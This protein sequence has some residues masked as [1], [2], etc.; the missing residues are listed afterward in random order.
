MKP[1]FLLLFLAA[2]TFQSLT[3]NA[4]VVFNGDLEQINRKYQ[5]PEAWGVMHAYDKYNFKLD[6][7][8]VKHGKYAMS[9]TSK[10]SDVDFAAIACTISKTF[11][12]EKVQLTGYLKTENV[13]GYAGFWVRIDGTKAF[14]NM[15]DQGIKGTNDWKEYTIT[16]PYDGDNAINIVAGALMVGTGKIWFDDMKLYLDGKPIENAKAIPLKVSK[17]RF[18]TAFSEKSG[19][20]TIALSNN[21]IKNLALLGQAWGFVKYHLPTVAEGD[22][23]MDAELFRVMPAVLKAQNS[24]QASVVIE[25]WIDRLGLVPA[26]TACAKADAKPAIK[27]NYG[28]LFDKNVV[29]A[30][31]VQKLTNILANRVNGKSY[32]IDMAPG[33]NNPVFK[34]ELPYNQM[35]YPDAGYRLL[36]LFRYWNMVNYFSP[37]RLI[38]GQQWNKVLVN[39]IP[40]FVNDK[41][42]L[43]YELTTLSLIAAVNDTHANIWNSLKP[44]R[45]YKGELSP[46]FEA[47]FIENQLTVTGF[48]NDTLNVK[49]NF[50]V[51]DVITSINGVKVADLIKKYLPYT[52]ASNY[53]TQLRDLPRG[54]LL[55]GNSP[56]VT[57]QVLRDGHTLNVNQE[58]L[59]RTKINFNALFP[60]KENEQGYRLI[61]NQIGYVYPARYYNKDLPAIKNLFK[62][63][64]GIIIDMRCYPSEFMP[65]TFVPYIKS[66][67]SD[68]VKFTVG[69]V[70]NPGQFTIGKTLSNDPTHEYKGKVVVIVDA[71]T[72]SQA[73][74]TTM[75]FQSSSNVTV[76]GS[77]T[78]GADGDV[79]EIF[80]P[81]GI[82]TMISGIGIFY[83]DGT[84]TQRVGVKIDEVIKPTIAGTKAGRDE[85]LER[86]KQ[87]ILN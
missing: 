66:N 70:S 45:E 51:G 22:V 42:G 85:L 25:Q 14:Y 71:S 60:I 78:A 83:P 69:S 64:K 28:M 55:R 75:A 44:L 4:Q 2:V 26:C 48:Y 6:S 30:S 65:F 38:I 47:K 19:I 27:P 24:K 21:T 46:P 40:R 10:S 11:A 7:S 63:T 17:A 59:Q 54:W 57:Y 5:F 37:N 13:S 33:I 23:N 34:N 74:Y 53:E 49:K 79:S 18:D 9:V 43:D 68:F 80:L 61:N 81:G 32:Y 3:A 82:R 41:N 50:K 77:T 58:S 15:A 29:T 12:G 36:C 72:Q 62:G 20:H 76:I 86:A 73:E 67:N 35:E 56:F 39:Y 84:P 16:L 31:L 1:C 52:P 8:V 87:I